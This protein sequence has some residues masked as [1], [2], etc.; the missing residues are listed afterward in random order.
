MHRA[1]RFRPTPSRPVS[2]RWR[3]VP[4]AGVDAGH[5]WRAASQKQALSRV[6]QPARRLTPPL[7]RRPAPRPGQALCLRGVPPRAPRLRAL[8]LREVPP[9]A[10]RLRARSASMRCAAAEMLG[11]GWRAMTG[12]DAACA[13][14]G[15]CRRPHRASAD[16]RPRSASGPCPRRSRPDLARLELARDALGGAARGC[17]VAGLARRGLDRSATPLG[18]FRAAYRCVAGLGGRLRC[19]SRPRRVAVAAA[20][21]RSWRHRHGP[22]RDAAAV[23]RCPCDG[24]RRLADPRGCV[25][26]LTAFVRRPCCRA[27][28]VP[29]PPPLCR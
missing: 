4:G 10:P 28:G 6:G 7:P 20:A 5:C 19:G 25:T 29:V 27:V 24:R 13:G 21:C 3:H 17:A 14:C 26:A 1:R 11:R 16:R 9:R 15:R 8:Y 23:L 2:P 22:H 18:R 12:L